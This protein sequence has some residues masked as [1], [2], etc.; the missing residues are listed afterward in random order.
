MFFKRKKEDPVEPQHKYKATYNCLHCGDMK[1]ITIAHPTSTTPYFLHHN[2]CEGKEIW[3]VY[4]L[5]SVTPLSETEN[6]KD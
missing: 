5:T 4:M 6:L 2:F 3:E 1:E